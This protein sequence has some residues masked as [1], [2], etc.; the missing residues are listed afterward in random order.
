MK[1]EQI[2]DKATELYTVVNDARAKAREDQSD[3]IVILDVIA[4]MAD[5]LV[6]SIR[7]FEEEKINNNSDRY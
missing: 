4:R 5:E 7:S 2:L 1:K 6:G 3:S